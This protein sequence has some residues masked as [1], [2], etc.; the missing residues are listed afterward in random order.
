MDGSKD[1]LIHW[2]S[3]PDPHHWITDTV[4][5]FSCL[6]QYIYTSLEFKAVLWIRIRK[7]KFIKDNLIVKF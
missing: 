4:C 3:V 7:K 2:S 6:L 5:T 1:N